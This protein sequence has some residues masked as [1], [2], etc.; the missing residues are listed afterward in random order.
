MV[1]RCF[2]VAKIVG[3]SPI[4]V[5]FLPIPLLHYNRVSLEF[6]VSNLITLLCEHMLL[7]R[8][9]AASFSLGD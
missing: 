5:V 6:V 3:S 8:G 1:R 2:P 7:K 4:G 9:L